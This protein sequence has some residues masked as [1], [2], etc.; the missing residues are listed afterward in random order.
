MNKKIVCLFFL[1]VLMV[2]VC[3][4]VS[5]TTTDGASGFYDVGTATNVTVV[6]GTSNLLVTFSR[7]IS[8]ILSSDSLVK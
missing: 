6:P 3:F 2:S 8:G 1:V 4:S 7:I 5:A